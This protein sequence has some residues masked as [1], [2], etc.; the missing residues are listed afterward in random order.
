MG[1]PRCC[2]GG[3]ASGSIT[4]RRKT[5]K[6]PPAVSAIGDSLSAPCYDLLGPLNE[7]HPVERFSRLRLVRHPDPG[8][9]RST[10]LRTWSS[11]S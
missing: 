11:G 10:R 2:A 3:D 6:I 7:T 9:R 1:L 5:N 4:V 8:F